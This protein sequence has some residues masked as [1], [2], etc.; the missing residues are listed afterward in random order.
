MPAANMR[1]PQMMMARMMRTTVTIM[2]L[3]PD[4]RKRKARIGYARYTRSA[5]ILLTL[6]KVRKIKPKKNRRA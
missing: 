4:Q 5:T 1:K 3:P 2:A 6:P